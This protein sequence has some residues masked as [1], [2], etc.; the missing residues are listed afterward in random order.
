MYE[1]PLNVDP[2]SVLCSGCGERPH[3]EVAA[4]SIF[5]GTAVNAKPRSGRARGSSGAPRSV[6]RPSAGSSAQA[7]RPWPCRRCSAG[8]CPAEAGRRRAPGPTPHSGA[9][10]PRNTVRC[11]SARNGGAPSTACPWSP[12]RSAAIARSLPIS[13]RS[14]RRRAIRDLLQREV[15]EDRG[16][17]RSGGTARQCTCR[18]WCRYSAVRCGT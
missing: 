14:T 18:C 8:R 11:R 15:R 1:L 2:W 12:P 4:S 7:G 5:G 17:R 9:G 13:R 16:R 3:G 10:R 6:P